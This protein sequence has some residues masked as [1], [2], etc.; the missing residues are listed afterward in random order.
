MQ[1]LSFFFVFLLTVC[2]NEFFRRFKVFFRMQGKEKIRK[3]EREKRERGERGERGEKERK[4]ERKGERRKSARTG[5][6]VC[7]LRRNASAGF[8]LF[9]CYICFQSFFSLFL[10]FLSLSFFSFLF[11]SPVSFFLPLSFGIQTI[12]GLLPATCCRS[13]SR[14]GSC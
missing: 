9:L 12:S 13:F 7:F 4:R 14:R 5:Q 6:N 2:L 8:K 10:S 11:P 3:K 1:K